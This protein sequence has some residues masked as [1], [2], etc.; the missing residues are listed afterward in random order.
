MEQQFGMGDSSG[1]R[2]P[3]S[4]DRH[5]VRIP[6]TRLPLNYG[7]RIRAL[8]KNVQA[9]IQRLTLAQRRGLAEHLG[10]DSFVD[11]LSASQIVTL[12]DGAV[13]WLTVDQAG[14]IVT[15]NVFQVESESNGRTRIAGAST[16]GYDSNR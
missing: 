3:Q 6:S 1:N 8:P 10:F 7:A 16:D 15:W 4:R 13:W 2:Q 14:L 5:S 12:S 9:S 11:L